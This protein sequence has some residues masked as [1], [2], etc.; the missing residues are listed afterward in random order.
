MSHMMFWDD[1]MANDMVND[2]DD[3]VMC[4]DDVD[5]DMSTYVAYPYKVLMP[6]VIKYVWVKS[7]LCV[8]KFDS[9]VVIAFLSVG[10]NII[11]LVKI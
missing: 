8:G 3:G 4:I 5:G 10:K 7:F 2:I 6:H 9:F 11:V 1:D